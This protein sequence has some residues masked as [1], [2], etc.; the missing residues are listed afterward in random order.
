MQSTLVNVSLLVVLALSP[1]ALGQS[2]ESLTYSDEGFH[3]GAE[4]LTPSK[5]AG[6]E[7]WYK[8][9]AGNDRFHTYVFQQRMGVLIDWWRVLHSDKRDERFKIWG[10][11]NNPGCCRPGSEGCTAKNL[12][13]TY[14]FNWCYGDD[15]LL[16]HV[17]RNGYQDPACDFEDAPWGQDRSTSGKTPAT[18]RSAPPPVPWVCA[19]SR[20][21]G[22]TP[23]SGGR[24]TVARWAPGRDTRGAYRTT[25]SA[26][27]TG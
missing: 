9:T 2:A 27:I 14:G 3:A 11:V 6:R 12:A 15:V 23:K 10:L 16:Q 21:P 4:G 26:P 19:S 5:R 17:G 22:S 8:A 1:W 25:R 13:K 24:S 18:W 7:I 20:I